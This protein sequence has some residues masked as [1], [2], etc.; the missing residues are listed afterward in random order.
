MHIILYIATLL[1]L[2]NIY[3]RVSNGL[4]GATYEPQ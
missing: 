2:V 1:I 3:K 4:K